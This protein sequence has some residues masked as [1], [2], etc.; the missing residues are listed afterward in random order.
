MLIVLTT[1]IL[2][3]FCF[4]AFFICSNIL[5]G[6]EGGGSIGEHLF[7]LIEFVF[8]LIEFKCFVFDLI[9]FEIVFDDEIKTRQLFGSRNNKNPDGMKSEFLLILTKKGEQKC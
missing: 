9:E 2:F 6:A 8:D 5:I 7:D 4:F 1:E 3:A